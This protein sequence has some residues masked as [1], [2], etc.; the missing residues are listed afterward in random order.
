MGTRDTGVGAIY[1]QRGVGHIILLAGE[2]YWEVP[3]E[4]DHRKKHHRR[5]RTRR[6]AGWGKDTRASGKIT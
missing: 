3:E 6:T 1:V 2:P 5:R 4:P